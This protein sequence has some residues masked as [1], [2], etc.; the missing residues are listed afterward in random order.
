MCDL[1]DAER[2]HLTQTQSLTRDEAGREVLVGLT[3]C[4]SGLLMAYRRQFATGNRDRDPENLT[5]WLELAERHELARPLQHINRHPMCIAP[6]VP[7]PLDSIQGAAPE[8][9]A[10]THESTLAAALPQTTA[11]TGSYPPYTDSAAVRQ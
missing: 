5:I 9:R 2:Q 11:T 7:P 10:S 6:A 1:T 8:P 4:E 3:D